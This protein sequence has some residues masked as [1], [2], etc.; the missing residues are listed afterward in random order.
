MGSQLLRRTAGSKGKRRNIVIRSLAF[1]WS[2]ILFRCW[3]ERKPY[4][5]AVYQ[6]AL[7]R[8]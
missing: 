5:E 8:G 7:D 6:Q 2:R 1:K 4:D 3:K